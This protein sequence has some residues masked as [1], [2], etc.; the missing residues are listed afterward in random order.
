MRFRLP[1]VTAAVLLAVPVAVMVASETSELVNAPSSGSEH[2]NVGDKAP[3]KEGKEGFDGTQGLPSDEE[4]L[5]ALGL[6]AVI[7]ASTAVV[8]RRRNRM[9]SY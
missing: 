5:L 2:P 1:L 9:S 3:H 4:G 7:A 8:I 6:A